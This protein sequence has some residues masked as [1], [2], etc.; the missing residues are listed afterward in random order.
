M[1]VLIIGGTRYMGRIAV[2]RLLERG[3]RVTV[4]SRGNVRPEWW[5]RVDHITGDRKDRAD[6]SG[7]LRGRA[8]DAVIDT[9]AFEKGD[10]ESAAEVFR[11]NVGRY[12]MVSTGSVRCM[13]RTP[14]RTSSAH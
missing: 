11:G 2:L 7:K 13:W 5:D 6:F 8:F 1:K 4:F 9:Q 10:V 12:L 14:R 3:D